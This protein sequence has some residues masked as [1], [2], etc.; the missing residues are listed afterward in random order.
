MYRLR[1]YVPTTQLGWDSIL[2][3]LSSFC[4]EIEG[5]KVTSHI[6]KKTLDQLSRSCITRLLLSS[7][8]STLSIT[9]FVG[10]TRPLSPCRH[11]CHPLEQSLRLL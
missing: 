9:G 11:A 8:G 3:Q 4:Y 7:E 6:R 1:I 2:F 10:M 5:G